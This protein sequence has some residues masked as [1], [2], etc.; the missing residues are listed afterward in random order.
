MPVSKKN[1]LSV[2]NLKILAASFAVVF[3]AELGDKTQL[4]ALAFSAQSR[5]QW[6]VFLGTSLALV[7]TSAL[8]VLFGGFLSR[9]LPPRLLHLVSGVM[10]VLIG[11]IMLVNLARKA[12]DEVIEAAPPAP[13]GAALT[14]GPIGAF[15]AGRI[16]SF[17]EDLAAAAEEQAERL[18]EGRVRQ[19]LLA[20]ADS[21]RGHLQQ[22]QD[23]TAAISGEQR[24]RI[25][26]NLEQA[27][28]ENLLGIIASA[29]DAAAD[30]AVARIIQH[31]EAAAQFYV[32]LARM[33]GFHDAR[34]VLRRLA[35]EEIR[36]ADELCA[37]TQHGDV[38]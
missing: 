26:R 18:P 15:V 36:L 28:T 38:V 20:V 11:L 22:L 30:D 1:G 24:T 33:I 25:D 37:L 34:D 14:P 5:S 32:A 27:Q 35:A 21:H 8:A 6:S 7:C 13:A 12:P 17:E 2:M 31:Q 16:V 4:T 23:M 3:L 10:F 9:V 29:R 19:T